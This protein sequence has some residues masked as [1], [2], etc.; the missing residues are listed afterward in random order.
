MAASISVGKTSRAN[1]CHAWAHS[2]LGDVASW[3]RH[4]PAARA[5]AGISSRLKPTPMAAATCCARA[6]GGGSAAGRGGAADIRRKASPRLSPTAAT[7]SQATTPTAPSATIPAQVAALFAAIMAARRDTER[8]AS[9]GRTTRFSHHLT[10]RAGH[11]CRW[12]PP[13]QPIAVA[14]RIRPLPAKQG[15]RRRDNRSRHCS[16]IDVQKPV[17]PGPGTAPYPARQVGSTYQSG[18]RP[19][20]STTPRAGSN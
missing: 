18:V 10:T 3:A 7:A 9:N 13:H 20:R 11:R 14:A 19:R 5:I 2:M 15:N 4:R 17:L 6:G 16:I 1:I 12:R 8:L